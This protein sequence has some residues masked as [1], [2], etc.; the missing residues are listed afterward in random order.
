MYASGDSARRTPAFRPAA[1]Q[2]LCLPHLWDLH[3]FFF[4]QHLKPSGQQWYSEESSWTYN[5]PVRHLQHGLDGQT[6]TGSLGHSTHSLLHATTS[7]VLHPQ[8]PPHHTTYLAGYHHYGLLPPPTGYTRAGIPLLHT[9]PT[10]THMPRRRLLPVSASGFLP[11]DAARS[12]H[13]TVRFIR[14]LRMVCTPAWAGRTGM[15]SL[16]NITRWHLAG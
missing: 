7:L 13:Q 8:R 2:S 9:V 3:S 6:L 4:L 12:C 11:R 15:N 5:M 16:A 1:G 14:R 10:A